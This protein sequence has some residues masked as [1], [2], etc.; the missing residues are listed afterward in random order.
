MYFYPILSLPVRGE[1]FAAMRERKLSSRESE[2]KSKKA[3][4]VADYI[5][6]DVI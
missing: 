1:M 5:G 6:N 3:F 4:E 2:R